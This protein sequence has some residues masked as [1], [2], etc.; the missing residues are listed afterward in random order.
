MPDKPRRILIID[1]M[2]S[3][4][5]DF[6]KALA[7]SSDEPLDQLE[8]D[9]FGGS[10]APKNTP[11]FELS[12]ASQGLDGI[13]KLSVGVELV[14]GTAANAD[15]HKVMQIV[16]NLLSNARHAALDGG[17]RGKVTVR[18][19][20][21]GGFARIEVQDDGCGIA[22][23]NAAK[24]FKHG[25]TTKNEGHGFGLHGSACFAME[26][27]GRLTCSSDGPGK[28]A[29]FVLELPRTLAAAA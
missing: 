18:A 15:P 1:D 17:R 19:G 8:S 20:V 2:E 28:G 3:I 16:M 14:A 25:F 27:G 6:A 7:R 23:E 10:S 11:E 5:A 26:M 29:R 13:E 12:F 21:S 22:P 9:L 4:H 24:I